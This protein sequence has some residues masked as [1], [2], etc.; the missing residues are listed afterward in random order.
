MMQEEKEVQDYYLDKHNL[1][2]FMYNLGEQIG[3]FLSFNNG[4]HK[5]RNVL[6]RLK[7]HTPNWT[8]FSEDIENDAEINT[9]INI[10]VGDY[11]NRDYRKTKSSIDDIKSEYPNI[12]FVNI[13]IHDGD[14]L[15]NVA[16]II[17]EH[18]V[19]QTILKT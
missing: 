16:R 6:V 7:N 1:I 4:Y 12:Q 8:N 9:I 19:Q 13:E 14:R 3:G 5:F 18:I 17:K 11:T 15:L 10:T 2:D